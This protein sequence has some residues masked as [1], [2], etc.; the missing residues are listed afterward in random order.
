MALPMNATP[1]YTL[2]IPSTGKDFKYRPFLVK[3]EKALLIAQESDDNVVILDTIKEVIKSCAKSEI[4]VDTLPSYDIEYIFLQ[5]RSMSIGELVEM[6]FRCDEDHGDQNSKAVTK[7]TINLKN[8]KV[9]R[10]EGHTNKIPLFDNVGVVMKYPTFDTL[11][12][13]DETD[14]SEM[15]D[16]FT[17]MVDCIDYIYS[18][19]EVFPS[20]DLTPQE[21]T[22]FLNNLTSA[23]FDKIQQFFR[24]IPTLRLD[25]Q[26]KCPVCGK[27]HD[28]YL[29]GLQSF[30]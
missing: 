30:F 1:I 5:L 24:T 17:V 20:K 27:Q 19:E 26:Y 12:K 22:D 14:S 6:L 28:K 3:D 2:T 21:L 16:V 25:I 18:D 10:V 29:E 8:I 23:Q 11:K 4:N 13:L 9:D 7:I 15:D